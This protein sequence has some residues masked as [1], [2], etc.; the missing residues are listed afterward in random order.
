MSK[1][2]RNITNGI[3]LKTSIGIFNSCN[4]A[5]RATGI[6]AENIRNRL[7]LGWTHDEALELKKRIKRNPSRGK[8]IACDGKT[9]NSMFELADYYE[10]NRIKVSKRLR[11]GWT[12][13][14]AVEIEERPPRYRNQDGSARDHAWTGK[15]ILPTGQVVPEP[16][17][18]SYNVYLLRNSKNGKEYVGITGMD[19]KQ[20]L[21]SHWRMVATGRHSKLYNAMRKA[22]R[23]G[24]KK[25]FQISLIRSDAKNFRE[26]QLQEIDEIEKRDTIGNGYN[27]AEGGA[28]GTPKSI[29]VQGKKFSSHAAAAYHYGVDPGV[30]NLRLGR[31]KYTPEQAAGLDPTKVYRKEIEIDGKKF[32]SK[33]S[34]A[35]F[36]GIDYKNFHRRLDSGWTLRQA[37]GIDAPPDTKPPH[38]SMELVTSI[39]TFNSIQHAAKV[40]KIKGATIAYR[41]RNNWSIEEALELD[42]KGFEKRRSNGGLNGK[43]QVIEG[44]VFA[45]LG[46]ACEYYGVPS[47]KVYNRLRNNWSVEEALEITPRKKSK[48]Y[49]RGNPI[50]TL[51]GDFDSLWEAAKV[52]KINFNKVHYRINTSGWSVN[53]ALELVK[54]E[55]PKLPAKEIK[56]LDYTFRSM[57]EACEEFG[58]NYGTVRNRISK[59]KWSVEEALNLK[60]RERK[61]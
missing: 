29:T 50:S 24:R 5:S 59:G 54:R 28:I 12:P 36:Y 49:K 56:V 1:G 48:Y 26:W 40:T 19:L 3:V 61:I 41:L 18:G 55:R 57:Q 34:A 46:K 11:S 30:F 15:A 31:L 10:H 22:E 35:K 13:E 60:P 14:Q 8:A 43:Q 17:T 38:N 16:I 9:F 47:G 25:D 52:L 2:K 53:E 45:S 20:R 7:S 37:A 33:R 23:E 58:L 39:G 32:E 21:R 4:E 27:T 44:K 6:T 51:I 42:K